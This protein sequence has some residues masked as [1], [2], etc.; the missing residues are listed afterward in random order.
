MNPSEEYEGGWKTPS[1]KPASKKNKK[2]KK[3]VP[4]A[5]TTQAERDE[6]M[7]KA[8]LSTAPLDVKPTDLQRAMD[9]LE[10]KEK[11]EA[12]QNRKGST[13]EPPAEQVTYDKPNPQKKGKKKKAVKNGGAKSTATPSDITKAV[14]GLSASSLRLAMQEAKTTFPGKPAEALKAVV[15]V[16]VAD[17]RSVGASKEMGSAYPL[18]ACSEPVQAVVLDAIN[19][20]GDEHLRTLFQ[21]Y[22]KDAVDHYRRKTP[23]LGI[24]LF[25]QLALQHEAKTKRISLGQLAMTTVLKH[26]KDALPQD[27]VTLPVLWLINQL[28]RLG[29]KLAFIHTLSPMLIGLLSDPKSSKH[30]RAGVLVGLDA[31]F[32]G[33]R[34]EVQRYTNLIINKV[35]GQ[36]ITVANMQSIIYLG[37]SKESKLTEPQRQ[38]VTTAYPFLRLLALGKP[39]FAPVAVKLLAFLDKASPGDQMYA[40]Q[41]L[42]TVN[43]A[44]GITPKTS[45]SVLIQGYKQSPRQVLHYLRFVN[46]HL[47]PTN[48]RSAFCKIDPGAWV[49][50]I[51]LMAAHGVN[52]LDNGS[53]KEHHDV[54]KGSLEEMADL[55]SKL[56]L[57]AKTRQ[58]EKQAAAGGSTL[59]WLLLMACLVMFGALGL[60]FVCRFALDPTPGPCQA[61][62]S[63]G[64][65]TFFDSQY[66]RVEP[67]IRQLEGPANSAYKHVK[68]Y[69]DPLTDAVSPYLRQAQDTATPYVKQAYAAVL[70]YWQQTVAAI[71]PYA[72]QA[73][74]SSEP[75]LR[76]AGEALQ[77]WVAHGMMVAEPHVTA[78]REAATPVL[79]SAVE[80]ATPYWEAMQNKVAEGLE[81]AAPHVANLFDGG[82]KG[83][84]SLY[85]AIFNA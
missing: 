41:L 62:E 12:Q 5:E 8:G 60:H 85:S 18:S 55:R 35:K 49:K 64:Y 79:Q 4:A 22:T 31:V 43:F 77:G 59:V 68:P 6:V 67:Y 80:S 27:D 65:L 13:P 78:A 32:G 61:L 76:Q 53:K 9:R 48:S 28:P 45:L 19:E 7:R 84:N 63:S 25:Q 70:P 14:Q 36:L 44:F 1:G 82:M 3:A 47:L 17:L 75:Y 23:S 34:S 81:M 71:T 10:A 72:H 56:V 40:Q 21:E 29:M 69:L 38:Q 2:K 37:F 42:M 51:D 73:W 26:H 58:Q 15:E 33:D 66:E 50:A 24:Q 52:C 46:R 83:F 74:E 16:L 39:K 54:I 57:I 11:R 20:A 30:V